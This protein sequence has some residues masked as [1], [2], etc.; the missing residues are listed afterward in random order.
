M[1][2]LPASCQTKRHDYVREPEVVSLNPVRPLFHPA[3][4]TSE[5]I[6]AS[7][8]ADSAERPDYS[9]PI[10]E[11]GAAGLHD[12]ALLDA[13]SQAV[14]G[15]AEKISPSVVKI[16]V[17]RPTAV[18]PASHESGKAADPDLYSLPMD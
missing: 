14:V 16:D 2:R 17:L 8:V 9:E 7:P 3:A 12:A 5:L 18:V 11:A 1:L 4:M 10:V 6:A 13:Y 15:A